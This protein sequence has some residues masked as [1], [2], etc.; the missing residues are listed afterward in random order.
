M[1]T[2]DPIEDHLAPQGLGVT[3]PGSSLYTDKSHLGH[4]MCPVLSH[5]NLT[6]QEPT[7]YPVK[8]RWYLCPRLKIGILRLR[9]PKWAEAWVSLFSG[10]GFGVLRGSPW[11][12]L[13]L[14]GSPFKRVCALGG[15]FR[16]HSPYRLK[17][18]CPTLSPLS[19]LYFLVSLRLSPGLLWR[20]P[21]AQ[22]RGGL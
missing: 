12:H 22:G 13:K 9:E 2:R 17:E 11:I 8:R 5:Q 16:P 21:P 3:H 10:V 19:G 7:V 15:S 18:V 14:Y 1:R 20:W 6:L 4:H